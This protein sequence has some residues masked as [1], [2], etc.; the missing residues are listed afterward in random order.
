MNIQQYK[1]IRS[2]KFPLPALRQPSKPKSLPHNICSLA[3]VSAY[4]PETFETHIIKSDHKD[5]EILMFNNHEYLK[6]EFTEACKIEPDNN[7]EVFQRLITKIEETVHNNDHNLIICNAVEVKPVDD[8]IFPIARHI[9]AKKAN[10]KNQ[11]TPCSLLKSLATS[12][13]TRKVR[14][15]VIT[16]SV[17][18]MRADGSLGDE[19][20][21]E[22]I[23]EGHFIEDLIKIKEKSKLKVKKYKA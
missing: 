20:N 23:N 6:R 19:L 10:N 5:T 13:L 3:L 9:Q 16:L 12:L 1:M 22:W 7:H 17:I 21:Y 2:N 15:T 14:S 8:L 4:Q 11:P 18:T